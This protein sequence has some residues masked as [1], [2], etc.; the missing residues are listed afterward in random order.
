QALLV[1]SDKLKRIG[2]PLRQDRKIVRVW[3]IVVALFVSTAVVVVWGLHKRRGGEIA[4]PGISPLALSS[5]SVPNAVT[6]PPTPSP[7]SSPILSPGPS[8]DASVTTTPEAKPSRESFVGVL[9]LIV[10]VAGVRREQLIDT[11][12]EARSE[13]RTHDAIDIPAAAGTPVLAA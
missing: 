1:E 2:H 9:N 7:S 8:A 11:F 12:S 4:R 3:L 13:G 6:P 5:T 10:P